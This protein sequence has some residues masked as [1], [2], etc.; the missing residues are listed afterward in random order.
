MGTQ[1][2]THFAPGWQWRGHLSKRYRKRR[3]TSRSSC[4]PA[5]A[6]FPLRLS[7]LWWSGSRLLP[8]SRSEELTF[9]GYWKMCRGTRAG[10]KALR[11]R[12]GALQRGLDSGPA[13]AM[14]FL[15]GEC[16]CPLWHCK[17]QSESPSNFF[18]VN[19]LRRDSLRSGFR[20]DCRRII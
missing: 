6:T 20:F 16:H 10:V 5:T 17:P 19:R 4:P 7:C 13:S 8:N 1:T 14:L 9:P 3:V 12:S 18:D 11:P 15:S 2:G